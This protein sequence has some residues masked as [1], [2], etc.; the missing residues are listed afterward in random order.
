MRHRTHG[1]LAGWGWRFQPLIQAR[2]TWLVVALILGI[3]GLVELSGGVQQVAPWYLACGLRRTEVVVGAVWQVGSYALLHGSWLHALGNALCL[4]VL[5]SRVEYILGKPG[6]FKGLGIG[7]LG[8]ALG[9]LV[10]SDGGPAA[11]PLVGI[12]GACVALLLVITT[13][14][15]ESRMWP[16]P[17]S[18]R[19]LGRGIL[20]GELL[21]ALLNPR[22]NLP[23]FSLLG[24]ELAR[25]GWESW[26]SVGHACHVGGG[27]AG[28]LY[29]R[30]ILRPRTTLD[31]LRKAR[32]RR[33]RAAGKAEP[34]G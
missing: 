25:H 5:G 13:L 27:V 17:V 34:R 30:A 19:N 32:Q 14:S 24:G 18:A 23:G 33:E 28:W 22:L 2:G 10:L 21:F 29:A 15:P 20:L 31:G 12:S 3:H 7:I 8:G 16:I 6:L 11:A 4:L 26:F 9:H 1:W